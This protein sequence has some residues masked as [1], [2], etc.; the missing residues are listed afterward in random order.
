MGGP[1]V[2]YESH[3]QRICKLADFVISGEAEFLFYDLC[4]KILTHNLSAI[5]DKWISGPLPELHQLNLPYTYYTEEDIKNRMIYVEAS[6]GCPFSCEY[7]L[8]SLEGAVRSFNLEELLLEF[9]ILIKRGAKKFKFLDRT[10]NL[11]IATSARILTFFLARIPLGLFLH[12]EMIPDRFPEELMELVRGFPPNS[13]QFEIG[14]QTWNEEVATRIRRKQDYELV[15]KNLTYLR[16]HTNVHLHV[17]LIAGLPGETLQSFAK[18]F[19]ETVRLRPQEIQLGILKKLKGTVIKRHDSEWG[20]VYQETSPFQ[21]LKT[22]TM[23]FEELRSVERFSRFWNLS[24]NS[25]NF[26]DTMELLNS[27]PGA[28]PFWTFYQFSAFLSQRHPNE[29]GIALINLLN[30]FWIYLS[31]NCNLPKVSLKKILAK[32]YTREK[33]RDIPKFLL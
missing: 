20:M 12:F 14:I 28:S 10:F 9:D 4:K 21:I 8:S 7:C 6:R 30:S 32:D 16:D 23:S 29:S 1:E 5:P 26:I 33:N 17:D 19:D 3:E 18:G 13:L 31:Q 27:S 11:N 2:S 15:R 24:A 22:S 25:G